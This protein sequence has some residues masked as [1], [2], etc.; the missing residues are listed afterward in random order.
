MEFCALEFT[1]ELLM[2][3]KSCFNYKKLKIEQNI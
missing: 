2:Y 1:I 3:G